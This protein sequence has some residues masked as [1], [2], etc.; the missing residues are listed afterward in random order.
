[1]LVLDGP[2]AYPAIAP[3]NDALTRLLELA[4]DENLAVVAIER[5]RWPSADRTDRRPTIADL[6]HADLLVPNATTMILIYDDAVFEPARPD[7]GTI[8]AKVVL[9]R[10]GPLGMVRL[11]YNP[12]CGLV[13]DLEPA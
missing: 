11:A 12:T 5:T 13:A 6:P 3:A 1:V 8:E 4:A 10:Y 2:S 7:R 9:N